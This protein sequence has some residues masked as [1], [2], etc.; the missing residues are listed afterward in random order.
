IENVKWE[1]GPVTFTSITG[2]ENS[3]RLTGGDSDYGPLEEAVSHAY[4]H[5]KQFT[6][7]L[8]IAPTK[9]DRFNWVVGGH[10]FWESL[11]SDSATG[12][13]PAVPQLA[14]YGTFYNDTQFVQHSESFA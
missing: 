1:A 8:R 2:Y 11:S 14:A 7:E 6:E 10:Y 13:L 5:A 9:A 3:S 12:T 4:A